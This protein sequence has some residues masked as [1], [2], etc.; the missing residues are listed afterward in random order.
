MQGRLRD[1]RRGSPALLASADHNVR[2]VQQTKPVYFEVA[3]GEDTTFCVSPYAIEAD[4][5]SFVNKYNVPKRLENVTL[6]VLP[7]GAP[8]I[9]IG[10]PHLLRLGVIPARDQLQISPYTGTP[11]QRAKIARAVVRARAGNASAGETVLTTED[12]FSEPDSDDPGEHDEQLFMKDDDT[13]KSKPAGCAPAD[14]GVDG[15]DCT[16]GTPPWGEGADAMKPALESTDDES[17]DDEKSQR[18]T[19]ATAEFTASC[20]GT[21]R[22]KTR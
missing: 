10:R 5:L 1:Q 11:Q 4:E 17:T 14:P 16:G 20:D 8:E 12:C 2:K 9:V 18:H 19:N 21:S 6:D 13:E 7:G 3:G 22:S 15:R